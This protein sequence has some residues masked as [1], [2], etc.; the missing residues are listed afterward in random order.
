MANTFFNFGNVAV[1]LGWLLL[2]FAPRWQ[3][4]QR[5][6]AYGIALLFSGLYVYL[7]ASSVSSFSMDSFSTLAGVKALF[8]NDNALAAGWLHYLAFDL[9]VGAYI[10]RHG[11]A[12]GI[13]RWLLTCILSVTFMF[14]PAGYLLFAIAT[15]LYRKQLI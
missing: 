12:L 4:T 15:M 11:H 3:Y 9:F 1:L 7:I 6:I 13:P 8:Q 10:V 2:V 14:G 5:L